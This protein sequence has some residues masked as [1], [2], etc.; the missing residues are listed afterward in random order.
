MQGAAITLGGVRI[1]G[2]VAASVRAHSWIIALIVAYAVYGLSVSTILGHIDTAWPVLYVQY[3]AS[4]TVVLLVLYGIGRLLH[5][6]L[7]VR[8]P[9]LLDHVR[10]DFTANPEV[11]QQMLAG[12]PLALFVPVFLSV[13]TSQKSLIPEMNAFGW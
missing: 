12:L 8:P 2:M 10:N 3:F 1:G 4:K 6:M 5:G 13:F 7:I 11:R 9:R